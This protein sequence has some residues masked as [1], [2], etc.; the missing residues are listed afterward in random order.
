M[1]ELNDS[2]NTTVNTTKIDVTSTLNEPTTTLS[3]TDGTDSVT[4]KTTD[5]DDTTGLSCLFWKMV[6]FLHNSQNVP[7]FNNCNCLPCDTAIDKQVSSRLIVCLDNDTKKA[8]RRM[9]QS[10]CSAYF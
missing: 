9:Q 10:G 7:I 5:S 8:N 6:T 2:S 1:S 4:D 3:T